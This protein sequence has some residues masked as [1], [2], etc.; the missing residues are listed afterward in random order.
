MSLCSV[1]DYSEATERSRVDG[2]DN[3]AKLSFIPN[4]VLPFL[5]LPLAYVNQPKELIASECNR[6]VIITLNP[7]DKTRGRMREHAL[8]GKYNNTREGWRWLINGN[9]FRG[10]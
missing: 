10:L 7:A 4:D 1:E 9:P 6:V 5:K 2:G 8:E 3:S